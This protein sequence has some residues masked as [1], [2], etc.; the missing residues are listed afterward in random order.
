[1]VQAAEMELKNKK[2]ELDE[3]EQIIDML[4]TGATDNFKREKAE[5]DRDSKKELKTLDI[6]S[7]IGIEE[8]KLD[9]E[10]ERVR[11]RIMKDLL[12]QY[13]KDE[14]DLDMKGLDALVKMAI[15][16]SKKDKGDKE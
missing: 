8:S 12:E 4:K 11:Q 16:Q 13:N 2:L 15:E 1:M 6:L 5:L 9:A 10:D 3:N 14:K 7:K